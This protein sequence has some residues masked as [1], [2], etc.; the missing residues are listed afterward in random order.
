VAAQHVEGLG[1]ELARPLG[2]RPVRRQQRL[3]AALVD[4]HDDGRAGA[5]GG[6]RLEEQV[7]GGGPRRREQAGLVRQRQHGDD[8]ERG[9]EAGEH[10]PGAHRRPP[11]LRT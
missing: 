5:L 8:G 10:A 6:A 2:Q 3:V 11:A 7:G 9:G 4:S 1:V